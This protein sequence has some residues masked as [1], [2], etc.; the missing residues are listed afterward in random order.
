MYFY[1][2]LVL[3]FASLLLVLLSGGGGLLGSGA[4]KG[5]RVVAYRV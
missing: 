3:V 1:D 4:F 5:F 2:C